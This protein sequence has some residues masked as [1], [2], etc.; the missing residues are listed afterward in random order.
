[1]S[2]GNKRDRLDAVFGAL[3]DP[4]RR[5]IVVRLSG[6]ETCVGDLAEP[7][8]VSAPAISRHLRVLESSGLVARRKVGRVHYCRL[9]TEPLI[10]AMTW[11]QKQREFW[12]C[13]F[14]AL[15]SYLEGKR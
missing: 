5:A 9:R 12:E 14:D 4:I 13:K 3:S 8:Q 10:R 7:F 6:G 15:G 11:M 2:K 1:M